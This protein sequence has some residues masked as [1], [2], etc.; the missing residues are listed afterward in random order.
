MAF[1]ILL[2]IFIGLCFGGA[3]TLIGLRLSELSKRRKEQRKEE[4][5]YEVQ[6]KVYRAYTDYFSDYIKREFSK[7]REELKLK[8]LEK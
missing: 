8:K 3:F 1:P 6:T 7:I 4:L 5:V 2:S